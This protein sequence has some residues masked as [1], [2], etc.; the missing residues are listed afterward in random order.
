MF[1]LLGRSPA[2]RAAIPIFLETPLLE[3]EDEN[4]GMTRLPA[5][6]INPLA[7]GLSASVTLGVHQTQELLESLNGEVRGIEK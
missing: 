2:G 6:E 3:T 1:I 4:L 7:S 5:T